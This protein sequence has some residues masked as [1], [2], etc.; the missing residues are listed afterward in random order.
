MHGFAVPAGRS[1][2]AG[3][4]RGYDSYDTHQW[5]DCKDHEDIA[6]AADEE[7]RRQDSSN[8]GGSE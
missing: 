6:E 5:L 1:Q 3:G 7:Q 2:Y 8:D 4:R